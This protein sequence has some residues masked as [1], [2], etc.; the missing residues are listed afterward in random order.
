MTVAI[1]CLL[2]VMPAGAADKPSPG[3]VEPM[4]DL[5]SVMPAHGTASIA[6]A[7]R[8]EYAFVSGNGKMGAMAF[9]VPHDETIVANHARLFLPLGT[10]EILPD[11]ARFLP[12]LR[13][14]IR[15]QGYGLSTRSASSPAMAFFL[16]EAK[17]QGYPGLMWTDPYHPGFFLTLKSSADGNVKDY[18]RTEDFAT[19]EVV[20]RWADDA[21]TW[22][23]RMFVSRADNVIVLSIKGPGAEQVTCHI[24]MPKIEERRINSTIEA[25]ADYFA[26]HNV[27]VF[28]KGGYDAAV[29]VIAKG[30]WAAAC[31][32]A[33]KVMAANEAILLM[34]IEPFTKAEDSK[35][36]KLREA[37][38]ALPADY[39]KLFAPHAKAHGEIFNRVSIDLAAPAEDRALPGEALLDQAA[40]TGK[41]PLALAEKMYDA[42]RYMFICS[43]GEL[44]PN[45]QGIW[46]GTWKPDWSGDFTLDTNVQAAVGSGLSCDM[47]EGMEGYYRL[48]ESLVPDWRINAK[49]YYGCR[50]VFSCTRASNTGLHL[51]WGT[52][53]GVFWTAGAG[54]LAHWFY[55]HYRYTGD[56]KFLAERTIPLLKEIALFYQDFLVA[57][58]D[59]KYEFIPAYSPETGCGINPTMDIAVAKEVLTNLIEGCR[60]LGTDADNIPKWQAMLDKM[61]DY[62]TNDKG[63]LAE[64][65]AGDNPEKYGHRHCSHLYPAFQSFELTPEK[66]PE[67]WE[68]ARKATLAKVNGGGE[69][70]SFN[71]M[72]SGMAAAYL[73]MPEQAYR[74][75]AIMATL[76][77]MYPSMITSHEPDGGILNTDGNGSIPELLNMMLYFSWPGRLDLLPALPDALPAGNIR[78][79]R[80][81]RQIRINDLTWNTPAGTIHLELTSSIAQTIT[82][83]LPNS[84]R[85]KQLQVTAGN[86]QAK[87]AAAPNARELTLPAG[88][89]VTLEIRF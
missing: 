53:P 40:K 22:V 27:Y 47:P 7:G 3:K 11:M 48:I 26:C 10:R 25:G 89:A 17:K 56:K 1:I 75:L 69:R 76:R 8:W 57:G 36:E 68:A 65:I 62:R 64:W 31:D 16:G 85:I 71:R 45:L 87:P 49:M 70:S 4:K 77:N 34:R 29:R 79:V 72:Q 15:E 60:D 78:G 83:R 20:V 28:G 41:C 44:P 14:I 86:A 61:P 59:G 19:G 54:W 84:E 5:R 50:G 38:A 63:E 13:K 30:G 37:L 58:A 46:T 6:P 18:V 52:W 39:G 73:R 42:G 23:R 67:L 55:D 24:D 2:S 12:E 88:A 21:G 51:H 35:P 33:I 74:Q 80:A 9:G 66:H 43:A 81:R 82:L 32:G